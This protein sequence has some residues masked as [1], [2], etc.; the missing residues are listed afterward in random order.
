MATLKIKI[1][2]SRF[3]SHN[4]VFVE[5]FSPNKV[6]GN[7]WIANIYPNG[8]I[9]CIT[10]NTDRHGIVKELKMT[11]RDRIVK[12]QLKVGDKKPNIVKLYQIR[13][14]NNEGVIGLS[15]GV[16][17]RRRVYLRDK[18]F[19]NFL[20]RHKIFSIRHMDPNIKFSISQGYKDGR[21][22]FFEELHS[23]GE[24]D[25]IYSY[26]SV[27][28]W[29]DGSSFKKFYKATVSS[30]TWVCKTSKINGEIINRVLYT[31]SDPLKLEGLPEN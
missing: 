27:P 31:V 28:D 22:E 14:W 30:A 26:M 13:E 8:E 21:C 4:N 2:N 29:S 16:V 10:T 6:I 12:I 5:E 25:Q 1:E 15:G 23:D 11:L 18:D 9:T 19:Q 17:E 20:D 24:I 7:G 3:V